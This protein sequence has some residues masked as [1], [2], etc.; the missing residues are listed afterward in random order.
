MKQ[1]EGVASD[2]T[3]HHLVFSSP[4]TADEAIRDGTYERWLKIA[5]DPRYILQQQRRSANASG[6]VLDDSSGDVSAAMPVALEP[7]AEGA[8]A[9]EAL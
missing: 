9:G 1:E 8:D 7:R 5:T 6:A 3:H 4:G 2:W